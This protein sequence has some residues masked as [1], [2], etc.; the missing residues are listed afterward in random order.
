MI[1]AGLWLANIVEN[2]MEEQLGSRILLV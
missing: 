2:R 1:S